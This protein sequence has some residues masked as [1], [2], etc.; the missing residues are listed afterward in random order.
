[1]RT[2]C[3]KNSSYTALLR[4][5]AT[6]APHT[7]A[8]TPTPTT[9]QH[10]VQPE[11]FRCWYGTSQSHAWKEVPRG[12]MPVSTVYTLLTH[13]TGT[14]VDQY[15]ETLQLCRHSTH[16]QLEKHSAAQHAGHGAYQ[17]SST[18]LPVGV[19]RQVPGAQQ[20]PLTSHHSAAAPQYNSWETAYCRPG[21][22]GVPVM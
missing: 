7:P 2:E 9:R 16:T 21:G 4:D 3:E 15:S 14:L 19:P 17:Q 10:P 1:V 5:A 13:L 18:Q 12:L 20:S 22:R 6:A 8:S 11:P